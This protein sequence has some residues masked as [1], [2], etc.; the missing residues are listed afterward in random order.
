MSL[1]LKVATATTIVLTKARNLTNGVLFQLVGTSFA[2]TTTYRM[3]QAVGKTGTAKTRGV[4]SFPYSYIGSDG[5]T[6][7][8]AAYAEW[9]TTVPITMPI[10]EAQKLPWLL[11]SSTADQSCTDLVANRSFTAV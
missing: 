4:I 10:T 2:M 11:Q 9:G 6:R 8:E 5:L 3:T 1:T 7:I